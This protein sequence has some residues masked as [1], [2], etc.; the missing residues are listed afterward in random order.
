ME[1]SESHTEASSASGTLA[2]LGCRLGLRLQHPRPEMMQG[3]NQSLTMDDRGFYGQPEPVQ[4][5][6]TGLGKFLPSRN[7]KGRHTGFHDTAVL[8]RRPHT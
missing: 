5:D 2:K 7:S 6:C 3:R 1:M 4:G 8:V